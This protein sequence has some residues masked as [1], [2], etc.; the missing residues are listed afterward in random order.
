MG[1]RS[2]WTLGKKIGLGFRVLLISL[3]AISTYSI[4][5][6][7]GI[8][9]NAERTAAADQLNAEVAQLHVDYLEWAD[10]ARSVLT[11]T[12]GA[13]L[14][15][16]PRQC[17]FG[18]WY[19]SEK[20]KAAEGLAPSIE[21]LL[22]EIRTPHEKAHQ[23]VADV[24]SLLDD[25][26]GGLDAAR[27]L[28]ARDVEPHLGQIHKLLGRT[29]GAVGDS[30]R[31]AGM[32]MAA[33]AR[34]LRFV[35]IV[36]GALTCAVGVA[37]YVTTVAGIRERL[38]GLSE[39][40]GECADLVAEVASQVSGSAQALAEGS[41]QQAAAIQETSASIEDIS[42]ATKQNARN[43]QEAK[44]LT[45]EAGDL[46]VQGQDAMARLS[47][48]MSEIK[49]SSDETAEIVKS[50]D[51][52]A[53][54]T[55]LLALNAAVEAARAGEAGRGFAVVAEEV[56]NLA[57]HAGRAAR[58]TATMIEGAGKNVNN[59]VSVAN[60]TSTAL[61][62]ITD[63]VQ[64]VGG[65]ISDIARAS[66]DQT[67]RIDQI[68]TAVCQVDSVTQR[69]A[70]S[71]EE[72]ASASEELKTQAEQ[73]RELV[74][75]LRAMLGSETASG[76]STVSR[77]AAPPRPAP[78]PP[79]GAPRLADLPSAAGSGMWAEPDD[80][81]GNNGKP[82]KVGDNGQEEDDVLPEDIISMDS[83]ELSRF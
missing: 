78:L 62:A 40:M 74:G 31:E 51:E 38:S 75:E 80:S 42:G 66:H 2:P 16:D 54:Q 24:I 77:A 28:Y 4:V 17:A 9:A 30:A 53:F 15:T 68:N 70:A 5:R 25:G 29:R 71:A 72:S 36:I 69:N 81:V 3:V 46:V 6:I 60:E 52:I 14:E 19:Y 13:D 47:A 22:V 1:V 21:A 39:S 18:K 8:M 41:C 10:K 33:K 64:R 7:G 44:D 34:S 20:R 83:D 73:Q 11:H 35:L 57:Q 48:T 27:D 61:G 43:A 76:G 50:I 49:K 63:S 23:A 45:A 59:G 37:F 79:S 56:R 67:Q 58:T 55:N 26:A 82:G 65:L 12:N 32:Q